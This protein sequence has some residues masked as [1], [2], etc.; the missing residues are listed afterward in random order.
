LTRHRSRQKFGRQ[1]KLKPIEV[2]TTKAKPIP[3]GFHTITPY[4]S[5]KNGAQA[6]EFYKK[7]FGAQERYRLPM[8]PDKI[9]HS[10]LVIGNSIFMLA[11]EFPEHG[12]KSPQ[13]LNGSPVGLALYVENVDQAFDRAIKA[14]AT[15]KEPVS[16][17]FWGD[18]AGSLTDPFGHK[19]TLL[20]H[21]EDVSPDEMKRRMEKLFPPNG[22][23]SKPA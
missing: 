22:A 16:D 23:K 15:V 11:D 9:G 10:E 5:V 4:L 14:G 19:W 2:M 3:D 17:K 13:S 7:A 8:G 6:I 12:S 20:T 21:I 18:R 1:I